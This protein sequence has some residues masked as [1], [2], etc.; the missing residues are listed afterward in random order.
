MK[1]RSG[2]LLAACSALACATPRAPEV[3]Y[4]TPD[5]VALAE[6][7]G[8]E[9]AAA[10]PA[11]GC[12]LE[13]ADSL[14]R[15]GIGYHHDQARQRLRARDLKQ[16]PPELSC[17]EFV[18]YV[19][20]S[21]GVDLGPRHRN[22]RK[23]AYSKHNY[24]R[25]MDRVDGARILPGDLLVYEFDPEELKRRARLVGG[26]KAGHVVLVV[27]AERR[28]VVGSHGE[29]STP[30]GAPEGVGYRSLRGDFSRWTEGRTLRAIY[31]P[32]AGAGGPI[33]PAGAHRV[34]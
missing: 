3:D 2:L 10:A 34:Q 23:L 19:Y 21:C 8:G 33:A 26:E 12:A 6:L 31:R 15:R 20:T 24:P 14:A 17:S 32:K 7:R 27:S 22:T 11:V 13:L 30:V 9:L 5:Q 28:I 29:A 25:G 16:P 1:L 18:W 4:L